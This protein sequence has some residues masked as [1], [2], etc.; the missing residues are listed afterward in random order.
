ME[1]M[2]L[3]VA[4]VLALAIVILQTRRAVKGLSSTDDSKCCSCLGCSR[5][6]S[7]IKEVNGEVK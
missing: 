7:N 3:A 5:S 1:T 4:G 2:L 6:C